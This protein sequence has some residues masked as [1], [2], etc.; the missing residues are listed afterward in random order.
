MNN[1]ID[2]VEEIVL[3]ELIFNKI[4]LVSTKNVLSNIYFVYEK[5]R[6]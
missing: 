3:K 1:Y 6:N 5:R 2:I 4:V